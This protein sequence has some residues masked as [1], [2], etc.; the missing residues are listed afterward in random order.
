MKIDVTEI[1]LTENTNKQ[2]EVIMDMSKIEISHQI[3]RISRKEPFVLEID[4]LVSNKLVIIGNTQI[5]I[6][7]PCDRCLEDVEIQLSIHIN[8]KI[9]LSDGVILNDTSDGAISYISENVLDV[10]Q[11]IY[12]EILVNWPLKILCKEDCKG[13]CP[14]CGNHLNEKECSCDQLVLDPRMAKIQNVF[15]EFKEV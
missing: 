1:L 11:L 14:V 10:D 13:I 4:H 5:S 7:A 12:N 8:E 15:K 9:S 3:H 6:E 2:F